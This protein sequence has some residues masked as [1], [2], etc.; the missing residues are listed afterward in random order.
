MT[1]Y[2]DSLTKF[3]QTKWGIFDMLCVSTA[4]NTVCS[5]L[6]PHHMCKPKK[7]GI[8]LSTECVET[9]TTCIPGASAGKMNP[10]ACFTYSF[11]IPFEM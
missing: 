2:Y 11:L 1:W 4:V 9:I 8:T 6:S 10:A 3:R 5:R 7:Y